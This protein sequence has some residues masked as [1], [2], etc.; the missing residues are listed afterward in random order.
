ME[1]IKYIKENPVIIVLFVAIIYL[2]YKDFCKKNKEGFDDLLGS[3]DKIVKVI[4]H[5]YK[6]DIESIRNLSSVSET[7]QKGG[8]TIPGNLTVKG[9]FNYLP[10]GTIVAFNGKSAPKGW[11]LC[12]G[13]TVRDSN[14]KNY[15]T[16]DLRGRFIY[17]Y[18]TRAGNNI[19][20]TGGSETHRLNSNEMPSHSHSG[21]IGSA[22]SHDHK[23]IQNFNHNGR[24]FGK[25]DSAFSGGGA[26]RLGS[27]GDCFKTSGVGNHSH[28]LSINNSG[29][30]RSH[31]NM[32][33]YYVLSYIV[34]L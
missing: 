10:R 27:G 4:N 12:N 17:G 28:R 11:A 7:L 9:D 24:C 22:G 19:G 23:T 14:G 5:V 21:S 32:P 20:R 31:N 2:L 6:I 13:R 15:R 33:P 29:G 3:Y 8:L 1:L 34:K 18:G 30:N 25:G 26:A 16:P